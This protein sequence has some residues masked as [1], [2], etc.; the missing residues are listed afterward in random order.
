LFSCSLAPLF[1]YSRFS[2]LGY[3]LPGFVAGLGFTH[4]GLFAITA[5]P[6]FAIWVLLRIIDLPLAPA[7][8]RGLGGEGASGR[9]WATNLYLNVGLRR[10]VVLVLGFLVGCTPWLFP[11]IQFARYGP[12]QG[13]DYGLP[14]HYFWGAP[15][16]WTDVFDLLTGGTVR[17]GMFRIPTSSD[18][19][20]TLGMLWERAN[21]EFGAIGLV[22][23]LVGAV[24]LFWRLRG[25]WLVTLWVLVATTGY[26]LLLGPAVAD[27]PIFTL[28]MLL[29]LA[30]WLAFGAQVLI[31]GGERLVQR[32]WADRRGVVL[33][34]WLVFGLLC[35][36]SVAW[37]D[38]RVEYASK[39]HLTLYRTFGEAVLATL[40]PNAVLITHWE[41]GMLFQYLRLV[42]QQ[43]PDVWIDVVEPAD[44]A[45]GSRVARRYAGRPVFLI[46]QAPDVAGLPVELVSEDPYALVF[47]L[48]RR[49]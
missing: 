28:P 12:F 48:R 41:Q 44:D 10:M 1:S 24:A 39:R 31:A 45:W 15:T 11:L 18:A 3:A 7:W 26:L 43:R 5:L 6:P 14:R 40:P 22:L 8:E 36:M 35:G 37:A 2:V 19:L 34:G 42:E 27:A 16:A 25:V 29:P 21:F 30:L 20:A 47:R 49:V 17:R 33:A 38:T 4:H 32:W 13:V 46:G 9:L 23:A